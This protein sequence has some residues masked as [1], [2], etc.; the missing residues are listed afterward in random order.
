MPLWRVRRVASMPIPLEGEKGPAYFATC[1]P[2]ALESEDGF[3][4]AYPTG[5]V[6]KV[7]CMSWCTS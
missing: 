4:H 1:M 3:M 6:R 7:W 2:L 5:G